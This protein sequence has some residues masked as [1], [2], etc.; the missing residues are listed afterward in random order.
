M[1]G[2]VLKPQVPHVCV[3]KQTDHLLCSRGPQHHGADRE[4][5][6]EE[7]MVGVLASK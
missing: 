4:E 7:G 1:M 5:E 2:P 3:W 6:E